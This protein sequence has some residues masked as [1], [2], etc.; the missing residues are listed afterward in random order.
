[1]NRRMN[2]AEPAGLSQ[3]GHMG[4]ADRETQDGRRMWIERVGKDET[5]SA[6][7]LIDKCGTADMVESPGTDW[8]GVM[9]QST[10]AVDSQTVNR[11][12]S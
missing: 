4:R 6:C 3:S 8:Q 1:M 7:G 2:A 9:N 12:R 11:R 5:A 10:G